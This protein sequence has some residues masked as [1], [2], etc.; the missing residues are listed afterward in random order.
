MKSII[1]KYRPTDK[2]QLINLIKKILQEIFKSKPKKL[3]IDKQ[4]FAKGGILFVLEH[5]KKIIGSV[6]IIKHKPKLARLKKTYLQK[7]F[8]GTGLAQKLLNKAVNFA[9]QKG[10]KKIILSTTSQMKA[11]IKFYQKHGFKKY[12]TNKKKNQIFFQKQL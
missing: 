6:G 5:N 12:K 1:R 10:Y 11:A 3:E 8:R 7:Q 9:K 2:K 4:F